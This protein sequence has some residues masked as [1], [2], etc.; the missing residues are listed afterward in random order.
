MIRE[1]PS[2]N[3][4][5]SSFSE[6]SEQQ[7]DVTEEA[8][9]NILERVQLSSIGTNQAA[10]EESSSCSKVQRKK[11]GSVDYPGGEQLA[12]D[13][14]RILDAAEDASP[15]EE[16]SQFFT[17]PNAEPNVVSSRLA[18]PTVSSEDDLCDEVDKEP[19]QKR[20]RRSTECTNSSL[21]FATAPQNPEADISELAARAA[22][23]VLECDVGQEED[24]NGEGE[25][26]EEQSGRSSRR[27]EGKKK[28]LAIACHPPSRL[29]RVTT[30]VLGN[31]PHGCYRLLAVVLKAS[32][33]ED[34]CSELKVRLSV[35]DDEGEVSLIAKEAE[36][37]LMCR[38]TLVKQSLSVEQ[39]LAELEGKVADIGVDKSAEG[40]FVKHSK[41]I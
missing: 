37:E 3:R 9:H 1:K 10:E 12:S 17:C 5:K 7:A 39:G 29:R 16:E 6:K 18:D 4:P 11:I 32:L 15:C 34:D 2:G 35:K 30:G 31:A 40:L 36:V 41:M 19:R 24:N 22:A 33:E 38:D 21:D 20:V 13:A 8:T 23:E 27:Q 14:D 25:V 26:V 28:L